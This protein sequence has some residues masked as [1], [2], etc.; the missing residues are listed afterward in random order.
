MNLDRRA[1]GRVDLM[2]VIKANDNE[3]SK[4]NACKVWKIKQE[5]KSWQQATS[6]D[7]ER[8]GCID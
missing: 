8:K 5:R 1:R 7:V 4:Q 3:K 6:L 2:M